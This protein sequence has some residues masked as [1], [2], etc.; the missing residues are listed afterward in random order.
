MTEVDRFTDE[1][2]EKKCRDCGKKI[3][4]DDKM[5]NQCN[6]CHRQEHSAR[7]EPA[8]VQEIDEFGDLR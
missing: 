6:D 7:R 4:T 3:R 5:L 1:V 8:T 2:E